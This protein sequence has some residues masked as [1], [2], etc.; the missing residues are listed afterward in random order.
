MTH[1]I[2]F[3]KQGG[4]GGQQQQQKQQEAAAREEEMR[5][6]ILGQVSSFFCSLSENSC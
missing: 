5:N 1:L 2:L 4:A 3:Q 6:V